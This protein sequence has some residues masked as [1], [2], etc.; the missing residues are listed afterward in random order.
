ML[1]NLI[2]TFGINLFSGIEVARDTF[3]QVI[4]T[5]SFKASNIHGLS[6]GVS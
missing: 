3:G 6:E 4:I 2:F 5:V 1:R